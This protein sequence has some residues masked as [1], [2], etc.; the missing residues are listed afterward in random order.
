MPAAA[1]VAQ[2][3]ASRLAGLNEALSEAVAGENYEQVSEGR[4]DVHSDIEH[5]PL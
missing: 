3:V 5:V 4:D 2:A 1:Y